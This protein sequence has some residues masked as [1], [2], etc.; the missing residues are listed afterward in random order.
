MMKKCLHCNE[1]C[2]DN[3]S[4]C[5]KCGAMVDSYVEKMESVFGNGCCY[6]LKIRDIGPKKVY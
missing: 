2:E 3:V 1:E 6:L 5:P 4:I